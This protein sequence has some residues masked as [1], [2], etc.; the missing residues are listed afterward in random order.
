MV[1]FLPSE[2]ISWTGGDGHVLPWAHLF[3]ALRSQDSPREGVALD[4]CT[5]CWQSCPKAH[6]RIQF[7]NQP[8]LQAG[9]GQSLC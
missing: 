8:V 7:I 1:H 3:M 6:R 5:S 9:T 4:P 2:N